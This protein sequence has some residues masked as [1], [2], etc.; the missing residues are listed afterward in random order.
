MVI[1]SEVVHYKYSP[2]TGCVNAS[3]LGVLTSLI[4]LSFRAG[5]LE[6]SKSILE[7]LCN[8]I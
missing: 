4:I 5:I 6:V 1:H 7:N 2:L 3:V 8:S